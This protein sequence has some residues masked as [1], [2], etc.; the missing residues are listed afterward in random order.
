MTRIRKTPTAIADQGAGPIPTIERID[1]RVGALVV[2]P[3]YPVSSASSDPIGGTAGGRLR[4]PRRLVLDGRPVIAGQRFW[5]SFYR[6]CSVDDGVFRLF[7]AEEVLERLAD[8]DPRRSLRFSVE[9]HAGG[10]D[11][12]I[13]VAQ[14][15]VTAL[16][17]R[18][19]VALLN[20]HGA[21][22]VTY[23]SGVVVS[24][25][26][27]ADGPGKFAIGPD[28]FER[29]FS[30]SIPIDG[31]GEPHV[32]ATL[33]RLVCRNGAVG[34]ARS[35]RGTVRLGDDPW[36]S[37]DR[38]IGSYANEDAFSAMRHRFEAAQR[39]WASLDEVGSLERILHGISWGASESA[40]RR[41]A[42]FERLVGDIPGLYGVAS[43]SA[44]S[45]KR[46]RLLPTRAR[47]FNLVN[48]ATELATHWAPPQAAMRLHAWVGTA[49]SDEFD[50][51][52]SAS[53]LVDFAALHL[54]EPKVAARPP[55]A[56]G[57]RAS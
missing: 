56:R 48:Y 12:L 42:D 20:A 26:V 5:R 10:T 15:S 14:R 36:H 29:R 45:P 1:A 32:F 44:I 35:F 30:L 47:M 57:R 25:H 19:L 2:D 27:P 40:G 21:E 52:G 51:E 6:A 37:L 8:R 9:R 38:A 43:V 55:A 17:P 7:G 49:I 18:S 33:L 46:R 39:S 3:E 31:Y 41:R 4:A 11:R 50:L 22:H 24:R 13:G 28:A 54:N 23:D 53:E 16:E 34:L